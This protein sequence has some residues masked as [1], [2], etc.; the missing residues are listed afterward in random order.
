MCAMCVEVHLEQLRRTRKE[1]ERARFEATKRRM[2]EELVTV[3]FELKMAEYLDSVLR[4]DLE[5]ERNMLSMLGR[6]SGHIPGEALDE[7]APKQQSKDS[8]VAWPPRKRPKQVRRR[9]KSASEQNIGGPEPN[10]E[11]EESLRD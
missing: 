2:G 9:R 10:K 7:E 5:K 1:S 8:S 4:N 3:D 11:R 6:P